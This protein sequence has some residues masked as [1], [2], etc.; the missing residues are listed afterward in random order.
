MIKNQTVT[1]AAGAS[2]RNEMT[3][4]QAAQ[5]PSGRFGVLRKAASLSSATTAKWLP[6]GKRRF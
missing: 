5:Q 2:D 1:V 3:T 4:V 6:G